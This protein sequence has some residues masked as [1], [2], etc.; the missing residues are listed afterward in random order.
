MLCCKYIMHK[1]LI[2]VTAL[3]DIS[4]LCIGDFIKINDIKD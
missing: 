3:S 4:L 1:M 2:Y